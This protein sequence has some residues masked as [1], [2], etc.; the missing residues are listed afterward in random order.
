MGDGRYTC[1]VTTPALSSIHLPVRD[2]GYQIGLRLHRLFHD[3]VGA[4]EKLI[5]RPVRVTSRTTTALP[6]RPSPLVRRVT[7]LMRRR[8]RQPMALNE[9]A[10]AL[11]V[12]PYIM[13]ATVLREFDI[14]PKALY[15]RI[16]RQAAEELLTG[17]DLPI[18]TIARRVGFAHATALNN[19]LVRAH[20]ISPSAFRRLSR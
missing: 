12:S 1:E 2:A 15:A 5:L 13:R 11:E 19:A 8:L 4:G 14:T 20:G 10:E 17:S 7:K 18:G 3:P 6:R 16:R 9:M